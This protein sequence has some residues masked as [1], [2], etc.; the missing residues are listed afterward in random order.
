MPK[1][2]RRAAQVVRGSVFDYGKM[3]AGRVQPT[4]ILF[5]E[6]I[7]CGLAGG[8][9]EIYKKAVD[10]FAAATPQGFRV[11]IVALGHEK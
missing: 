7:G 9:W 3:A 5:P 2:R 11:L 4:T 8:C 10:D 6:K 1:E